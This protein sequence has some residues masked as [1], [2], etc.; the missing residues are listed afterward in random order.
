MKTKLY[1]RRIL[2]WLALGN[3]ISIADHTGVFDPR[4][5]IMSIGHAVSLNDDTETLDLESIP[6]SDDMIKWCSSLVVF[7]KESQKLV[8]SHFTVE[9]FLRSDESEVDSDIARKYQLPRESRIEY[10]LLSKNMYHLLGAQQL[11]FMDL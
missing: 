1:I 5:D 7:R 4:L 6:D 8:L 2:V 10:A 11:Q 3:E 9:E